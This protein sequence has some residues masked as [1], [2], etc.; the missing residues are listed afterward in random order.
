MTPNGGRLPFGATINAS[1]RLAFSLKP[2]SKSNP[3]SALTAGGLPYSLLFPRLM[4]YSS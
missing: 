2:E 4:K 1:L 3:L